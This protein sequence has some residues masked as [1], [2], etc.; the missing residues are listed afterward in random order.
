MNKKIRIV[1]GKIQSGKTTSLFRFANSQKSIDGILSP[2]VNCKRRLYHISSKTVKD[3][4]I[5]QSSEETISV[6]KYFFLKKSFKWANSKL[7][8]GFSKS[9]EWLIIDEIGKLELKGEG[10]HSATQKILMDKINSNTKIILVI[11]DYLIE[12]ALKY[13]NIAHN[14]YTFLEL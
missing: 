10:F 2:I 4:E 3:F 5:D 8:E 9:P 14:D 7:L 1:T 6:G 12:E 13:Y 11:R